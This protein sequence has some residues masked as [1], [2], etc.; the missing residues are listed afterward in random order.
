MKKIILLI[1]VGIIIVGLVGAIEY[2]TRYNPWTG[3]LDY[4]VGVNIINMSGGNI[5]DVSYLWTDNID[6]FS[7]TY[8]SFSGPI[9]MSGHNITNGDW[10]FF[11]NFNGTFTGDFNGTMNWTSLQNYPVA[12]PGSG[13]ITALNDSV[14][15]SDLW[16]DV[17]GDTM[18]GNLT[19]SGS[20]ILNLTHFNTT[21]ITTVRLNV[22]NITADNIN[23]NLDGQNQF[24]ISNYTEINSV[25]YVNPST[26][27][28]QSKLQPN[29]EVH[30]NKGNYALLSNF[31]LT[32]NLTIVIDTGAVIYWDTGATPLR[33][34][35][36]AVNATAPFIG[37]G[38]QNV[39]VINNG[40][41]TPDIIFV[42]Y[43][44]GTPSASKAV[45][46]NNTINTEFKIGYVSHLTGAISV[47]NSN[48]SRAYD[49]YAP[50]NISSMYGAECVNGVQLRNLEAHMDTHE[51][52]IIDLNGYVENVIINN[53]NAYGGS[54]HDDQTIDFN[55]V[56]NAKVSNVNSYN[57]RQLLTINRIQ[58][59]II[60]YGTCAE[61]NSTN[62][63]IDSSSCINC[64]EESQID[65]DVTN[66]SVDIF[67]NGKRNFYGDSFFN[68]IK[69]VSNE[70]LILAYSF[71]NDSMMND[72]FAIDSSSEENNLVLTN[73]NHYLNN[74]FNNGGFLNFTDTLNSNGL[75]QNQINFSGSSGITF[76]IWAKTTTDSNDYL[77]DNTGSD[78]I[79]M[80]ARL[81]SSNDIRLQ[82][83]NGTNSYAL[84]SGNVES[85]F[86]DGNWHY[87]VGTV[88]LS[89]GRTDL[90]FDGSRKANGTFIGDIN[91]F[92]QKYRIGIRGSGTTQ[93]WNGD[94]DEARI[95]KRAL[96]YDEVKALYHQRN[97][98]EISKVSRKGG[99]FEGV[100][101]LNSP[102][103]A[104]PAGYYM[105]YFNGATATCTGFN[106]LI[107]YG[108]N[109]LV[110]MIDTS[111]PEF[112]WSV[113]NSNGV[114]K[115]YLNVNVN[116]PELE[117]TSDGNIS[118]MNLFPKTNNLYFL[119]SLALR[120][121]K[122]WFVDLDVSG[123]SNL[124][125]V[126]VNQLLNLQPI[127][128]PTC[129]ISYNGTMARNE[130]GVYG[131]N[132]T[133]SWVRI[134]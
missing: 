112:N 42:P 70:K 133:S 128:L 44:S 107:I 63:Q 15:C 111:N 7:Q 28:I 81:S 33:L 18:T 82:L 59:G 134:F 46:F 126:T 114:Y 119:G 102:P 85:V 53:I 66:I 105:T 31:N 97:E 99:S 26:A 122:G 60:R 86:L 36:L 2:R 57:A 4:V 48:D 120:W 13:A 27:D 93:G 62:I 98:I 101:T 132:A 32:S 23:S 21:N 91:P 121:I 39:K 30:F 103:V 16:V 29:T 49:G 35:G 84:S 25:V 8:V 37:N 95:Y 10:I 115:V 38:V 124:T 118:V 52:E 50:S 131:C 129:G 17:A 130:T 92:N 87:I 109:P 90:Y 96:S 75:T 113:R 1:L 110:K 117:I 34:E 108:N 76:A 80:I 43:Y 22:I 55:G 100:L 56:R 74:G 83:N 89:N 106:E 104:C 73:T 5:T 64:V 94:L 40:K 68:E 71:N 14:T 45:L 51:K 9:N 20:E 54:D 12:C 88:D 47:F 72:S 11:N 125:N 58:S 65:Y 78:E 67:E 3:K 123:T 79:G 69:K 24:I 6:P 77:F 116:D 41:I 127:T 19:F 61:F